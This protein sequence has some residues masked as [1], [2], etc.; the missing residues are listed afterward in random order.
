VVCDYGEECAG[1]SLDE[2]RPAASYV[3]PDMMLTTLSHP[4]SAV[5]LFVYF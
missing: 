3:V 4:K 5:G 1:E 2:K